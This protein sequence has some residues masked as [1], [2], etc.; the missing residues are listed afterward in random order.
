MGR[1]GGNPKTPMPDGSS[2]NY[3]KIQMTIYL[4]SKDERIWQLILNGY[5][6]PVDTDAEGKT[7]P[8]PVEKWTEA[9]H[10]NSSNNFKGLHAIQSF[11]YE[12]EFRKKASCE[13][14]KQACD[15]LKVIYE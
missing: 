7:S 13:T 9:D 12:D 1:G 11:V 6:A 5:K 15:T 2:Y 14:S 4:K 3:W 10:K 8:K